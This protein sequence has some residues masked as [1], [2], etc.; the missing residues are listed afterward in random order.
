[1][2]PNYLWEPIAL[3]IKSGQDAE[4]INDK[5]FRLT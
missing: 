2:R 4:D 5:L 3:L 1:M